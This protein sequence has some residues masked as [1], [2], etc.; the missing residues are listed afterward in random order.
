MRSFKQRLG[1]EWLVWDGGMGTLLQKA[2]LAPG[3]LPETWNLEN[4]DKVI[5]AHRAYLEAGCDI[6][7]TNTFGANRLKFPE[8]L[9]EIVTAGVCNARKAI[10][11]AGRE[12]DA[13]AALDIG[14]CGKLL[15]PM[16]DL[17]FEEAV[18]LFAQVVRAGAAA[19]ADLVLIE[20]MT[21]A[22]EAKAAVLAAKENC[23]LPVCTTAAFDARG[24]LLTGGTPASFTALMEGLG[25]DAIGM[26]CGLGP[27][28]MLPAAEEMVRAASIPVIVN[29]NAGLP[30]QEG[31][32][33]VYDLTCADFCEAM[34]KIAAL[35]VQVLGGC[36]GTTPA[37][38]KEIV[39]LCRRTP[40]T[41]PQKKDRTILSSFSHALEIGQTPLLIGERINPTGKK[42]FKQALREGDLDYIIGEG[43]KQEE[44]G[45][46]ILDVNV[47]LPE[48]D[49]PAMMEEV[50]VRL[51]SVTDL[52]LQIDT[53]NIDALERG[54]RLYNGKALINSVNGKQESMEAVFPLAKKYGALIVGLC[55]DEDGIP[56]DAQG[57]IR[58]AAKII[59]TAASY[60]IDKSQILIDGLCMAVSSDDRSGPVTLETV[61]RCRHELGVHTIL[62]VSNVSFG[63]PRR[64]ILNASF[65]SLALYAGLDCAIIN[66]GNEAMMRAYRSTLALLGKDPR[67]MDYIQACEHFSA[68]I[69]AGGTAAGGNPAAGQNGASHGSNGTPSFVSTDSAAAR[70]SLS[71]EKG[72]T[73]QAAQAAREALVQTDG[74]TLIND[75]LIPA[76]DRVGKGFEEGTLFLPQLLMSAE[77][78]KAAFEE[79]KLSM[80]G[81]K[82]ESKGKV[83]LA[84]VKND[85]HDIGKNIVKILL[86]NYGY[87]VIDLGNDVP[88]E[89]IVETAV[90][91]DILLVGLSALMTTTVTSMAE[92][93]RQ[94]HI[95]R[96]QTKVVVGGAVMTQEYAD[97]IGADC[98]ARDAMSTVRYA[99]S[100]FL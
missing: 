90:R 3:Q 86:E 41:P 89:K 91:E 79:V 31:N 51:Q 34:E 80:A 12:A 92:T 72:M 40:F 82:R 23:D 55:L 94:L 69:A 49:E 77:A 6:I 27:V 61:R 11:M 99:D 73:S 30:R 22:Y 57:R 48:I 7:N 93:I 2:G 37:Y 53:T 83:I 88:P 38:L 96:P 98:Y 9:A 76:L 44:A 36:C 14:P 50:V 45:A 13:Y 35:G 84:T 64:E 20:T 21:D 65:F 87:D 1:R 63:L 8:N 56:A 68:G 100:I 67:C 58:I 10:A 5:E 16:G 24:K 19:G 66:P 70:L 43:L 17:A 71:I 15:A 60:G 46:H 47:G 75:Q 18:E 39:Q 4:P 42:R 62:G 81:E 59:D 85:I 95:S 25:V 97:S 28:Q 52:P 29:P 54:L 32:E 33:T 74:L 78:A 26:N